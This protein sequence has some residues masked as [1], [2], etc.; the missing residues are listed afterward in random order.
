MRKIL[1]LEDR[2][3][4]QKIFLPSKEKDVDE[5]SNIDELIMPIADDCKKIISSINQEE[6]YVIGNDI[7]LVII[8]KTSLSTQGL[9]HINSICEKNNID[10][11]L[12]SGGID[13]LIYNNEK[14]NV[15]ELN[16]SDF[17]TNRLIPFLKKYIKENHTNLLE[18]VN[19]NWQISY[20]FLLRQLQHTHTIEAEQ[21]KVEIDDEMNSRIND[22][23]DKINNI[24]N[25]L[26]IDSNLNE[27]KIDE[28][29]K[30][31]LIES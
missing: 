25:I 5:L 4:R 27:I 26:G 13:Q 19:P 20:W 6:E 2:P 16:S 17:Y 15:L 10:L 30:K 24:V 3:E 11:I 1:F 7:S 28:K 23:H 18:L 29:I 14:N 12:F 21:K 8:H 9:H 22:L 31:I